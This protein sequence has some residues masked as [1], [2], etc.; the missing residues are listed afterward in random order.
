MLMVG[1]LENPVSNQ[2]IPVIEN[3][4]FLYQSCVNLSMI[5]SIRLLQKYA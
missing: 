3:T 2:D 4:K 1:M 5:F